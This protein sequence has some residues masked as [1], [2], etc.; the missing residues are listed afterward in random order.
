MATRIGGVDDPVKGRAEANSKIVR[1]RTWAWFVDDFMTRFAA[2]SGMIILMTRW[3][4][5]DLLGR[6]LKKEPDV[7][8][9]R[10]PPIAETDEPHRRASVFP[11][12]RRGLAMA[13]ELA[14]ADGMLGFTFFVPQLSS[15]DRRCRCW[16]RRQAA[17]LGT[18]PCRQRI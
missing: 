1:D 5:D 10:F 18:G 7:R 15:G 16:T 6:Q 2:L 4:V 14:V 17:A 12:N 13:P 8:I 11:S 9:V 3:H